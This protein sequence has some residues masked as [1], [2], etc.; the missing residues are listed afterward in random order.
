MSTIRLDSKRPL[1]SRTTSLTRAF[2]ETYPADY[3]L[4]NSQILV[5]DEKFYSQ[6]LVIFALF[7]NLPAYKRHS[8]RFTFL[9]LLKNMLDLRVRDHRNT[10]INKLDVALAL[11]MFLYNLIRM[12]IL[13]P[14]NVV[15]IVTELL[16]FFAKERCA[17]ALK[18]ANN[19]G[20]K[21]G[22]SALWFSLFV[23]WLLHT[24]G[25]AITSPI[26][27]MLSEGAGKIN[28]T[29]V[30]FT[31]IFYI[32]AAPFIPGALIA[33]STGV[34]IVAA[35]EPIWFALSVAGSYILMLTNS[36]LRLKKNDEILKPM[37]G[38]PSKSSTLAA[39]ESMPRP[40]STRKK[41]KGSTAQVADARK[42]A[43]VKEEGPMFDSTQ[44][45]VDDPDND[46][47]PLL[48]LRNRVKAR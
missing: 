18:R 32:S 26:N 10:R 43:K 23:F 5:E 28:W 45:Y 35:M 27:G 25:R 38:S 30:I 34:G 44:S 16:P 47:A 36:I 48:G 14:L 6:P 29:S 21:N 1:D 13:L 46:A 39:M 9:D 31:S 19:R 2:W 33:A 8:D 3:N 37:L 41:Q 12:L 11:P 20:E 4:Q 42:K 22:N 40:E 24:I 7:L 15:K 17:M